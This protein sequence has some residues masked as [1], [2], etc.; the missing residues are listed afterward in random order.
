MHTN[1]R[2]YDS[3]ALSLQTIAD[4]ADIITIN[5]TFFKNNRKLDLPGFT[6]FNRNRQNVNCGG[7]ATCVKSKDAMNSLK[8]FEGSNDDEI[9]I[10]RHGQFLTA[11]GCL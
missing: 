10:T 4:R 3:K 1:I 11:T 7:I 5:E 6:C 9:L 2:G 8:V